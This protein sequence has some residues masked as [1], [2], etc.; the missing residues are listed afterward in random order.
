VTTAGPDQDIDKLRAEKRQLERDVEHL[1]RHD[2]L[3]GLLNRQAF[4]SAVHTIVSEDTIGRGVMIEV[5]FR[6]APHINGA[7]RRHVSDYI[8]SAMASRLNQLPGEEHMIGRIDYW[9]FAVFL[10]QLSD[11]LEA[12]A[13]A[14]K[15]VDL[16]SEP[17]D[18][19]DSKVKFEVSAG[20][21]LCNKDILDA[22]TL[23]EHASIA[24][25]SASEKGGPG[26]AFF[27]PLLAQAARKRHEIYLILQEALEKNW[28]HLQYQPVFEMQGGALTG[29]EALVR[30]HHPERGVIPPSDFIPV[31][32]ETGIIT[33]LGAWALTEACRTAVHWPAHLVVA[34]NISPEQFYTGT[35][36][37]DVHH[38]LELSSMPHY[39]LELEVT[40]STLL[41]D[42]EVV[43][44]QLS[45][46]REL[47]CMVALDDFG[48]GYSSLS[49]LWKFPFSK[50]KIDRSFVQAAE[51][52]PT[53][54]AML[55]SIIDL[56]TN[57]G[58]K[59]TAEG[60][61]TEGQTAIVRQYGCDFVQGFLTGRP[62]N[63]EDLASIILKNFTEHLAERRGIEKV[64]AP[65]PAKQA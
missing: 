15:F 22:A 10:P 12:L 57:L 42:S 48:T 29:F 54:R 58:L 6:G 41:K 1:R 26:Y 53:V 34:V 43:L 45:A 23:L 59:T 27:N 7:L 32:E 5:G 11:P 25:K 30:L 14:K 9:H 65:I 56:S 47:G 52:N 61:E 62:A 46:L 38:A 44:Q 16:L 18:W 40:E 35:L 37:T 49:Y 39:R 8:L 51:T 21:A 33:K 50:L 2:A 31:A 28:F 64:I 4:L 55:K 20:V 63:A 17:I 60:I 19:I 36:I 3:T 24:L 13:R